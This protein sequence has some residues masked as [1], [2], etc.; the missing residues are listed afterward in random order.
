MAFQAF[1]CEP[2]DDGK[3]YLRADYSV[4]CYGADHARSKRLAW[5][6]IVCY[7]IGVLVLYAVLLRQLDERL[8]PQRTVK[9]HV[10]VGLWDGAQELVRETRVRAVLGG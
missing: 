5:V 10:Q 7:P 9:V 6:G 1:S 3:S 2:F 4:Q 8:E